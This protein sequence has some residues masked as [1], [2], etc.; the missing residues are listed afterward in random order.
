MLDLANKRVMVTGGSG[1]LGGFVLDELA[2]RGCTQV[3]SPPGR[4]LS[5]PSC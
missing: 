1:F 2:A 4:Q 3:F 5:P